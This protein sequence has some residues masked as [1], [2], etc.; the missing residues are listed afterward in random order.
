MGIENLPTIC[1]NLYKQKKKEDTH[2]AVMNGVQLVNSAC[3][4]GQL[5]TIVSIVKNEN[6]SNPSMT[7]IGDV[8]PLRDRDR[9]KER[10]PLTRKKFYLQSATNKQVQWSKSYKKAGAEIYIIPTFKKGR[11]HITL[12]ANQWIF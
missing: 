1:E 5:S 6:I 7:I 11:I 10:N 3:H 4:T 9:L 12:E 8:V 2:V